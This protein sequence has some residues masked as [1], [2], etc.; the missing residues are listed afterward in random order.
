MCVHIFVTLP[1]DA[2]KPSDSTYEPVTGSQFGWHT[3]RLPG[4]AEWHKIYFGGSQPLHLAS[5]EDHQH[6]I[7]MHHTLNILGQHSTPV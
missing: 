2:L 5:N 6:T 7:E 3:T 4:G 1:G